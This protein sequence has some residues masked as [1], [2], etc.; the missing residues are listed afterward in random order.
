MAFIGYDRRFAASELQNLNLP[1]IK[2]FG[3]ECRQMEGR[4][5]LLNDLG[6]LL[7]QDDFSL[8]QVYQDPGLS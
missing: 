1:Y 8:V 2:Q 7:S 4:F 3:L 5:D 6:W